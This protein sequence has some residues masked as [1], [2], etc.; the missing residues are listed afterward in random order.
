MTLS[1]RAGQNKKNLI[2]FKIKTKTLTKLAIKKTIKIINTKGSQSK[3][4]II[5]SNIKK[6]K[7]LKAKK[8]K[9]AKKAE[10]IRIKN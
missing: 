7:D 8:A 2:Q 9:K 10:K 5:K 3:K 1:Q 4:T 6:N